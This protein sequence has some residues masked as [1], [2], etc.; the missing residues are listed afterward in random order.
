MYKR[1]KPKQTTL[2]V[3]NSKE[4]E[5]IEMKMERVINNKEPIKDG[6]PIVY[7]ERKEGVLPG[8]NIR[9]DRFD[10]AIDAMDKVSKTH[11]AKREERIKE[12]E[13]K[14][15]EMNTNTNDGGAEPTQGT[16]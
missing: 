15:I 4:G 16:Q 12:K 7:T 10:V 6:A 2:R 8:Y 13:V 1:N 3:N 9:T 5:T 11:I 14:I